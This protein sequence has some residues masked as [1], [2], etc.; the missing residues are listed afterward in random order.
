[1][2]YYEVDIINPAV[3]FGAIAVILAVP[4]AATWIFYRIM[5]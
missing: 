3:I 1:M 5:R 2:G 4:I